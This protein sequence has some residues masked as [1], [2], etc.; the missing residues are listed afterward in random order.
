MNN[1]FHIKKSHMRTTTMKNKQI[2][3]TFQGINSNKT[4]GDPDS[5]GVR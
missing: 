1:I 2:N 4:T 5:V 3:K